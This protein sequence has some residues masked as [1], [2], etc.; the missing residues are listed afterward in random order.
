M[1]VSMHS[2]GV[3]WRCLFCRSLP[4]RP[5][6]PTRLFTISAQTR[7]DEGEGSSNPLIEQYQKDNVGKT[8]QTPALPRPGDLA[9]SSIFEDDRRAQAMASRARAI[10]Q[11]EEEEDEGRQRRD[12][13]STLR[14]LDPDPNSR[15]R[16]ERKKV[17][18]MVRKGGRLSKAQFIKRTEREHLVKSHNM[19][20]SV[21]KLG[22]LARQIAGKNVDD[23]ILQM[24]FS[25]KKAATE[26]R[27]QLETARDEAVVTRG[28][29]LGKVNGTED[30]SSSDGATAAE[31]KKADEELHIRLKSGKR[32]V[33]SDRS[34]IYIDQAWVGRGPYGRLPDYRAKGRL[35]IM[36]TPF[37]SLS[38]LL[39]EEAT[40]IREYEER[41]EK[42]TRRRLD[43][44][45]TALRDRPIST[46][47][48]WYS[49]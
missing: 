48:Q 27:K 42:R 38:L 46:Q 33:V 3:A 28:M 21:K 35:F 4:T 39:K 24:R 19:K 32:H 43:K 34:S 30:A 6:H 26:I 37:T 2:S 45:W 16:W 1:S 44:V 40:R 9:A 18:Q 22:M 15:E 5:R 31:G 49:W 36:R 14:V 17:I 29:G 10:E 20:T 11:G 8:A 41:E 13:R 7:A 25:K 23:A 12:P 47:R